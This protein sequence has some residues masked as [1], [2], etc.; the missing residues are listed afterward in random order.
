[1]LGRT[2]RFQQ[3]GVIAY[4]LGILLLSHDYD[5]LFNLK[6]NVLIRL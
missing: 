2:Q 6:L 3:S 4:R 5:N 1:M